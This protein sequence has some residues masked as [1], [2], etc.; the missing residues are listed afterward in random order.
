MDIAPDTAWQRRWAAE[1]LGVEVTASLTEARTALLRRLAE[2]D[3][4]PPPLL[5]QALAILE[6]RQAKAA[7]REALREEQ[8]RLRSEV[9]AFAEQFWTLPVD[10]RRRRWE[11]LLS[12]CAISPALLA[13]VRELK[14][15][16]D[17]GPT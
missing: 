11:E 5:P 2:S 6:G 3:F 8:E 12:A 17:I 14:C 7:E 10:E 13:R 15:G 16:L 1:Q 9:E 4:V